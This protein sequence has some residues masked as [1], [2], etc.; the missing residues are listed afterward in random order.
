MKDLPKY[1]MLKTS[2]GE[3]HEE[4]GITGA[5]ADGVNIPPPPLAGASLDLPPPPKTD[6]YE[7]TVHP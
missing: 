5:D 6:K 1:M 2:R 4:K 7:F 3:T